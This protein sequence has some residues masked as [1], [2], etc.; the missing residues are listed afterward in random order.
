MTPNNFRIVLSSMFAIFLIIII[1]II[2]ITLNNP[3][4]LNKL[5]KQ[6]TD[7][8]SQYEKT[9]DDNPVEETIVK[10]PSNVAKYGNEID[11]C[12]NQSRW[13]VISRWFPNRYFNNWSAIRDKRVLYD[14][15]YPPQNRTD[16]STYD[17]MSAEIQNRNFYTQTQNYGDTFRMVGYLTNKGNVTGENDTGGNVWKLLARQIDSNRSQFYMIPSNNNYGIKI[18]LSDNIIKGPK[19]KDIYD[20]PNEINFDTPL[21]SSSPYTFTELPK[22]D[23]TDYGYY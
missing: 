20:I 13:N 7:K 15:L 19:I 21:L 14:D 3:T 1:I 10:S 18:N 11:Q 12:N 16:A 2:W 4:L 22:N 17:M 23:F 5:Q 8:D 6:N 9:S